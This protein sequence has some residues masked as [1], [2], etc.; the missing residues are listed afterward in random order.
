[1]IVQTQR[2]SKS[3][4]NSFRQCPRRLWLEVH[5][6]ELKQ[7]TDAMRR[8]FGVGHEVGAIARQQ[9]PDGILIG[10][11]DNLERAMVDTE[12]AL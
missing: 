6:P 12:V 3:R 8:M 1:M 2:L 7:E 10:S 9:Y 5:R 11:D 4:L